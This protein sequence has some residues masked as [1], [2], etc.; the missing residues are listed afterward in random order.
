MS[1]GFLMAGKAANRVN[2]NVTTVGAGS[3]FTMTTAIAGFQT[4][5]AA[6]HDG[7][8]VEYSLSDGANSEDGWGVVGG[9]ATTITRNIFDS[10]NSG[11]AISLSGSATCIVTLT[12]QGAQAI[13]AFQAHRIG[14]GI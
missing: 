7:D 6:C 4:L 5:A 12:A 2:V 8:V 11:A 1:E 9:G 10:T 13:L 3:P 14:G